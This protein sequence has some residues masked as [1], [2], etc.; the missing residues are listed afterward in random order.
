ME[1]KFAGIAYIKAQACQRGGWRAHET[2]GPDKNQG[3]PDSREQRKARGLHA[4]PIKG[5]Q[6][7]KEQE[8]SWGTLLRTELIT[9]K[10]KRE[11]NKDSVSAGKI[12][13]DCVHRRLSV[14]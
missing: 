7:A 5:P 4:K 11:N 12:T 6:V 9:E 8:D 10:K 2:G 13:K 3:G 14:F 1:G